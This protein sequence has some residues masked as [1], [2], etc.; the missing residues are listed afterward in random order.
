MHTTKPSGTDTSSQAIACERLNRS[1]SYFLAQAVHDLRQPLQA[2]RIYLQVLKDTPLNPHQQELVDKASQALEDMQHLMDNYLDLSRLDYGGVKFEPDYFQLQDLTDKLAAE[3]AVIAGAQGLKFS[4][5]R[6]TQTIFTDKILLE[7]MLRNL[8]SNAFKYGR[9]K[10]VFGCKRRGEGI[11][12]IVLDNGNCINKEDI[13]YIFDEFYQ[14][15]HLLPLHKSGSGLGLSI[16]K[17]IA[18]IL[19]TSINIKTEKGKGTSFSFMLYNN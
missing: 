4:Y 11:Q 6:C 2:Q 17:K 5:I 19:H 9:S 16:V 12:I 15:A 1:K 3:F 18:D 8:L 14:S 10:V 7:R 13:P